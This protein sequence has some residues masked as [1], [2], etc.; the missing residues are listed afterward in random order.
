LSRDSGSNT[1]PR[2]SIY[3]S[4]YAEP[5]PYLLREWDGLVTSENTTWA[6]IAD[7]E[8]IDPGFSVFLAR[9]AAERLVCGF[10]G[11]EVKVA[12]QAPQETR[13]FSFTRYAQAFSPLGM[14]PNWLYTIF[15]YVLEQQVIV[16]RLSVPNRM[17]G[18]PEIECLS[19]P[20]P[21]SFPW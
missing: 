19:L 11:T 6:E 8:T 10:V 3:W 20:R 5:D 16:A 18:T 7:A 13:F 2:P 17:I 9:E 4:L 12:L 14:P 15:G 21:V 1:L